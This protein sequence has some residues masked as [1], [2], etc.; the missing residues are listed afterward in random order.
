MVTKLTE[1]EED[2][3]LSLDNNES[4]ASLV[5]TLQSDFKCIWLIPSKFT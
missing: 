1:S 5:C 4:R 3:I 2:I